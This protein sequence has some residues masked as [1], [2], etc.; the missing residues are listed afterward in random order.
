MAAVDN[1]ITSVQQSQPQHVLNPE[2]LTTVHLDLRG[3]RFH[4]DRDTLMN[5]P[6]SV[7]LCLF[8]NGLVL[9][10]VGGAGGSQWS[11]GAENEEDEY[12]YV[13]DVSFGL[14]FSACHNI[15]RNPSPRTN[16][17]IYDYE[18]YSSTRI[19]SHSSLISSIMREM[20]STAPTRRLAP[21]PHKRASWIQ[22]IPRQMTTRA[23]GILS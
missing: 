13:V 8:P 17:T 18:F 22:V 23:H 21:S 9:S 11:E 6:E 16:R 20:I 2:L 12:L 5:L 3:R 19:A 7:L 4:V 14:A 1:I 15:L 10:R